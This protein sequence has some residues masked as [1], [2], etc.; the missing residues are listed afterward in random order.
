MPD[1]KTLNSDFTIVQKNNMALR[2]SSSQVNAWMNLAP[3]AMVN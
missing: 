1:K 3:S 2:Y